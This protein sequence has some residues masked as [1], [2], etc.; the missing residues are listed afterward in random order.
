MTHNP[1]PYAGGRHC[2]RPSRAGIALLSLSVAILWALPALR[3]DD[4]AQ[5][6]QVHA[7][8]TLA[9]RMG[10]WTMPAH[11]HARQ[12]PS[13][14]SHAL[15]RA[16]EP[17]T[18]PTFRP[19][20]N[21]GQIRRP[22][23]ARS[24]WGGLGAAALT[25][26]GALLSV[27]VWAAG[28]RPRPAWSMCSAD[29]AAYGTDQA[30]G[31]SVSIVP[32][33]HITDWLPETP[34]YPN[35]MRS[36]RML[37]YRKPDE[38]IRQRVVVHADV[39]S[40]PL[41]R[42]YDAVLRAGPRE[43]TYFD[44]AEVVACVVCTGG[45]C[46]GLNSV[47]EELVHNLHA[48]Y[49]VR[50]VLGIRYGFRG[51][52]PAESA[53]LPLTPESVRN[54]HTKGGTVLGTGRGHFDP[55]VILDFVKANRVNMVF[56]LGG[57]GSHRA[58]LKIHETCRDAALRTVVVGIPKTVDNDLLYIDKT[59]GFD[60]AVG[61][62]CGVIDCAYAEASS[63][64]NGVGLVKLMGRDAGL[65]A[66]DAALSNNVVDAC[67]IPEIPFRLTGDGG[68]LPWL[69]AHL[70]EHQHAVV[71]ISEAAA[72]QHVPVLG[73]D[74]TGHNV[75]EDTGK[76]MKG[77]I[78]AHW[79][80]AGSEGKVFL[81][82]PSYT[83][84]SVPAT[85]ADNQMCISLAQAAVH[86]A[87]SGYSGVTVGLFHGLDGV[88]PIDVVVRGNRQVNPNGTAWQTLESRL[89]FDPREAPDA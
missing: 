37:R 23:S 50:Q 7:S 80:E 18:H 15:L 74:P 89:S 51:F 82:D 79:A 86:T 24:V 36:Y 38:A 69:D 40:R 63:V 16:P 29:G 67:L 57:D 46:P 60:T 4:Q 11:V 66:Q 65:V 62:A 1:L 70:A 6:L 32:L 34:T 25:I 9:P 58:A 26:A 20:T 77:L 52:D 3:P 72:Q 73:K 55:D 87:F 81:I 39:I 43:T 41:I 45:L 30:P 76:W 68:F 35:P 19:V 33:P 47:I 21:S 56:V 48:T 78:E 8:T 61:R 12:P 28:R 5:S 44:S 85:A 17:V 83:I 10:S 59:F 27:A 71:V 42:G 64:R 54:I 49:G 84:R 13:L 53:P 2:S 31:E 88:L 22:Q 14:A 75:Y